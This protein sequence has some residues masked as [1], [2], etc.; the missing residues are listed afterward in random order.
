MNLRNR[1]AESDAQGFIRDLGGSDKPWEFRK[2]TDM[3]A[4]FTWYVP[5]S[6]AHIFLRGTSFFIYI[7]HSRTHLER[8]LLSK[9]LA[10]IVVRTIP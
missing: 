6:S 2:A 9:R 5:L 3:S 4:N 10:L 7:G 1:H 8:L